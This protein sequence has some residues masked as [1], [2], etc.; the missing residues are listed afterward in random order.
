MERNKPTTSLEKN[1]ILEEFEFEE[2]ILYN[3]SKLHENDVLS[4]MKILPETLKD[5]ETYEFNL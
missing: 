2:P 4:S 1:K 5:F 3:V